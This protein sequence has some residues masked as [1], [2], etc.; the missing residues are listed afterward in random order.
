MPSLEAMKTWTKK[1][2]PQ[3][4]AGNLKPVVLINE[5]D[6]ATLA[7]PLCVHALARAI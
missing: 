6:G 3:L 4:V 2:R 7:S 5:R 1:Y